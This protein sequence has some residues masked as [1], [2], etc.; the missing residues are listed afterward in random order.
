MRSLYSKLILFTIGIMLASGLIAFLAVNTFYHQQLK[1]QNDQKNIQ[2]ATDIADSIEAS[3][4]III[5]DFF[6]TIGNVGYKIAVVNDSRD[7]TFYGDPFRKD[8]LPETAIDLVL[9]GEN[10][11]GM[12]DFPRETFVTGFFSDEVANTAGVPFKHQGDTYALFIRPNIKM[13]FTEVHYLLGGMFI[14]MGIVS[15]FGMIYLA[16]RLIKPIVKLTTATQHI[17]DE[18]F[19]VTLPTTR[20]DEIGQLAGS[21]KTMTDKL[22]ASDRLRKQFINDVTHDFQTPLQNIQGYADLL[23]ETDISEENR[24]AYTDIIQSETKRLSALTKQLLLLTT[25]DSLTDKVA[26]KRVNISQQIKDT[27]QNHRWLIEDKN[28]SIMME[29]PDCEY[30]GDPASLEK[31]WDNLLSNA[32]KYSLSDGLVELH[33]QETI[34]TVVFTIKDNGIGIDE[35]QLPYLFDR[36]YRAD[37]SRHAKISGTGLGLAIVEQVIRLHDGD[38]K[39]ISSIDDGS[40]F[41]VT[42]PKN[43]I[44]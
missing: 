1:E 17:S 37:N 35:K 7:T 43:K 44:Q 25:L 24:Q 8:N 36:F 2:I 16:R 3:E 20:K 10:Y 13:L 15:L 5:D 38:I 6:Q 12:R 30:V 19:S 32:I 31:I 29:I 21:F 18:E 9:S 39:V 11:H 28:I 41:E 27:L 22:A 23:H 42:L 14:V 34:D 26:K 40:I 4:S 33:L